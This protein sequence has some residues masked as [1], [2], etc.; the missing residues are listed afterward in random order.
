MMK[1]TP[2]NPRDRYLPEILDRMVLEAEHLADNRVRQRQVRA[3]ERACIR[4]IKRGDTFNV[5]NWA[6]K[7]SDAQHVSSIDRERE[8]YRYFTR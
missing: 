2:E 6:T 7:L 4:A 5:E 8:L 3:E 1:S